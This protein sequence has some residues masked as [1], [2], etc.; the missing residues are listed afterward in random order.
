VH[1]RMSPRSGATPLLA[2]V[3]VTEG[4]L[5]GPGRSDLG[6]GVMW[7]LDGW[8]TPAVP[9]CLRGQF[10]RAIDS[11]HLNRLK[12]PLGGKVEAK[13]PH[14]ALRGG[15][16]RY[17]GVS[18]GFRD[19][20]DRRTRA[21]SELLAVHVVP[22]ASER[23]S[24]YEEPVQSVPGGS[25]G[26]PSELRA[27]DSLAPTALV[28]HLNRAPAHWHSCARVMKEISGWCETTIHAI[29]ATLLMLATTED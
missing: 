24:L 25:V 3:I 29:F 13:L 8:H 9:V 4:T 6:Q 5:M 17:M 15:I 1:R 16:R 14:T 23:P 10:L 7:P 20:C 22:R 19:V 18:K 11:S 21:A 28:E 26:T 2:R 12:C 27:A